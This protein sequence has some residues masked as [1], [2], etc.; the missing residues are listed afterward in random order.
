MASAAGSFL[1]CLLLYCIIHTLSRFFGQTA[2]LE[3]LYL[4]FFPSPLVIARVA[5]LTVV[6]I[7]SMIC[8]CMS[9]MLNKAWYT[10]KS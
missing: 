8:T 10:C 9:A 7:L 2:Y 4:F 6:Q 5:L 1:F 3:G